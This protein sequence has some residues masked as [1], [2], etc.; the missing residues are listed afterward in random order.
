MAKEEN[1]LQSFFDAYDFISEDSFVEFKRY[2]SLL[3]QE[4]VQKYLK[5]LQEI[6]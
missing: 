3:P 1:T 2:S 5:L 6:Q 4:V